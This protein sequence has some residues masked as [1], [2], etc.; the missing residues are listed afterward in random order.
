MPVIK[1]DISDLEKLV[2]PGFDLGRFSAEI[3]MVGASVEKVQGSEISVEFFPDRPDLFCVEGAARTYRDFKGIRG[4]SAL[5]KYRIG[6]DSG[7]VLDV[8]PGLKG[9]RPVIGAAYLT[10]VRIDEPTLISIMNL[11]EKLHITV[12][13]KRRKVAIGIHD[14]DPIKPPFRFWAAKPDEVEFVPLQKEGLWNLDRILKEHEKGVDYAWVLEGYDRYPVITDSGGEVL[15]FPPIINGELTKVSKSTRNIFVDC[16]GWDLNAV[17]LSVNIVCSQLMDRGG[18][19][20]SV[21][22]QYPDDPY[23]RNMGLTTSSWPH[24]EWTKGVLEL[25][26]SARWLGISP[27]SNEVSGALQRMGYENISISGNKL[28]CLIPPWRGDILHQADIA[29]DLAIGYGFRRFAGSSPLTYMTASE[30]KITTLKRSLR[31]SLVGLGFLEVTTIS[32]S[33]EDLQFKLMDRE[34]CD[35]LRIR[36]PITT[37]HTMVRMSALPSLMELLRSNK[38]RDL[39]QRIFEIA[40]VMV[41]NRNRVLISGAIMDNKASFTMVKGIVQKLLSDLEVAYL[42]GSAALGCYIKG[43]GAALLSEGEDAADTPFPELKE[44]GSIPLGHFGEVH[45]R[46]IS[47]MDLTAPVAAFELDLD[48]I[49]SMTYG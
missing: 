32:L 45:P 46:M 39:P 41:E 27:E 26:W 40:D 35:H 5:E 17:R 3:P 16:T 28:E 30:R 19:L 49:S 2:G 48:L 12:G 14:A 10:D 24:F 33:S 1:M 37:E 36:N 18:G 9:I 21:N 23:F 20:H 4:S 47:E 44:N 22:V 15:S 6:N 29:E 13:R 38:H 7:I 11:Q 43:R 34:E 31:E 42:L 8:D 25:D